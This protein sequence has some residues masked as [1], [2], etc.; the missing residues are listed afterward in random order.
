MDRLTLKICERMKQHHVEVYYY[1]IDKHA[2]ELTS[3]G[4]ISCMLRGYMP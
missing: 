1:D 3:P 2:V 4:G